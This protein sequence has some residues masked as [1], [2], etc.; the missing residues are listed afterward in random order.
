MIDVDKKF[1]KD[2]KKK[3]TAAQ[4]ELKELSTFINS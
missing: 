1:D 4:V 3:T 2:D